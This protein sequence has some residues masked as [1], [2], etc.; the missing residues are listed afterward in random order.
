MLLRTIRLCRGA[1]TGILRRRVLWI[2]VLTATIIGSSSRD[3]Q[4]QLPIPIPLPNPLGPISSAVGAG[5]AGLGGSAFDAIIKHLFA[6][7]AHFVNVALLGWLVQ[8]P[9]F[10]TGNVRQLEST[11]CAMG[12]AALGAVATVAVARYWL[13]GLA[14]GST[15]GFEALEGL[16]RTIGAAL[17]LPLWPWLFDNGVSRSNL[18]TSSLMGSGS[19]SDDSARLLVVG[20]GAA[21]ALSATGV[22]EFLMLV[23]A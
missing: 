7:V 21:G 1:V 2:V 19:V 20:L 22:G 3:A 17:F 12:A 15:T 8:V 5:A 4:A 11:V 10:S 9:D 13:A 18:F 6:P 16:A 14:G 23:V